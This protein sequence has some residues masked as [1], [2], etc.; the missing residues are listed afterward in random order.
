M[1]EDLSFI[2]DRS[3]SIPHIFH[4]KSS[5][6]YTGISNLFLITMTKINYISYNYIKLYKIFP[7]IICLIFY[8]NTT[9]KI[10][11]N[12]NIKYK[13]KLKKKR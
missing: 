8:N 11:Y 7:K 13:L 2:S 6:R 5:F 4:C 3:I 1:Q 12:S 10:C 9:I